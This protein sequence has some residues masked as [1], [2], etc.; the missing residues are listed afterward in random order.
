[1]LS[2]LQASCKVWFK[3]WAQGQLQLARRGQSR[4]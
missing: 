1:M 2:F 3:A 4:I